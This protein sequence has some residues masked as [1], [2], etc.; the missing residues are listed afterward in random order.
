[1]LIKLSTPLCLSCVAISFND[2]SH[3][4]SSPGFLPWPGLLLGTAVSNLS[5]STIAGPMVGGACQGDLLHHLYRHSY[6]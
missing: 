2:Y 1:M 3:C 5:G 6:C 4:G